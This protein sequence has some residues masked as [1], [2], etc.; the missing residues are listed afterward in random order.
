M[1][2]ANKFLDIG[3]KNVSNGS[4][5]LFGS[6]IGAKNLIS[7]S[8]NTVKID[9]GGNL[10]AAPLNATDVSGVVANPMIEDLNINDNNIINYC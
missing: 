3:T 4:L 9:D 10:F 8:A 2:F 7:T 6:K 5:I 1:S